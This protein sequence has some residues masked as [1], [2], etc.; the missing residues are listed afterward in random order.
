MKRYEKVQ[1]HMVV[2]SHAQEG[3]PHSEAHAASEDRRGVACIV[4]T[5]QYLPR[6]SRSR[7]T[8]TFSQGKLTDRCKR[9]VFPSRNEPGVGPSLV[10]L[11]KRARAPRVVGRGSGSVQGHS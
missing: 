3:A 11:Q 1:S 2:A 5:T 9:L 10:S 6:V 7:R 8:T 4:S